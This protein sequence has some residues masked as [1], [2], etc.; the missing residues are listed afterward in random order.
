[1]F[2]IGI[3][4]GC[5]KHPDEEQIQALE[6]AKSAALSAEQTLADKKREAQD[7][8]KKC[9]AAKT[10]LAKVQQEKAKVMKKLEEKSSEE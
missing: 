6:E 8:E 2:V 9:D 10:E 7:A 5:T 3:F 4:A 1:L